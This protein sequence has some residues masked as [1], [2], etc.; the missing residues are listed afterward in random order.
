MA[1][2]SQSSGIVIESVGRKGIACERKLFPEAWALPT[3]SGPCGN[4]A[5]V[6][7]GTKRSP[8]SCS[9]CLDV[10]DARQPAPDF[11]S[12]SFRSPGEERCR[13][14]DRAIL[15]DTRMELVFDCSSDIEVPSGLL[16]SSG[17]LLRGFALF[18]LLLDQ[19]PHWW[20]APKRDESR[21]KA[22]ERLETKGGRANPGIATRSLRSL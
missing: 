8:R 11:L 18:R 20:P 5:P 10:G 19:F 17:P 1:N 14:A 6:P 2:P 22:R 15:L 12:S 4:S 3:A 7:L 21:R 16:Y 13:R 9:T